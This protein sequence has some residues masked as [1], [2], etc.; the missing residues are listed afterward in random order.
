MTPPAA[1]GDPKIRC[2]R[3]SARAPADPR[4]IFKQW[5]EPERSVVRAEE[6]RL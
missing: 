2:D 1:G 4:A 6:P 3:Q 5:N